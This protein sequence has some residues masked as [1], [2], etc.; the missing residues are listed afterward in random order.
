MKAADGN[1]SEE[2]EKEIK[3]EDEL[4]GFRIPDK[5]GDD[6]RRRAGRFKYGD[7]LPD[8]IE[9]L[10]KLETIKR[11]IEG[12]VYYGQVNSSEE[13]EGRGV[14]YDPTHQWYI[15]EGFWKSD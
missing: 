2:E 8:D 4:A 13:R 7:T 1:S 15:R 10:P 14:F 12:D 9:P 3:Y 5:D 11:N 6:F